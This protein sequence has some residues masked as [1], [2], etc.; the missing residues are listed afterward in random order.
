MR[1]WKLAALAVVAA[2]V[3]SSCGI[4]GG[5]GGSGKS[6]SAVFQRAIQVFPGVGVRVLGVNVGTVDSIKPVDNGVQVN[7]T[8]SDSDTK[9]PEDVQAVIAPQSLL[10][11]RFVQLFPAYTGGPELA[12]GSTIP[13]SRTGVPAEPDELLASLNNYLGA[14][15][16]STVNEFVTNAAKILKGN[17]ADLNA[18]IHHGAN[19]LQTLADKRDDLAQI[20]V[21]FD[22]LSRALATRQSAVANLIHTYNS[23]AGTLVSNRSALEGTID[24]LNDASLQL[25]SLLIAHRQPLHTD[26]ENLTSTAQTLSR[27]IGH[28]ART[29]HWASLLF[30]AAERA[31]DYN[32][33]WLRLNNQGQELAA[34][35]LIRLEQR[36]MGLC[37]DLGIPTCSLPSYWAQNVP[38]LF[39]FKDKCTPPKT[40][41]GGPI[42]LPTN[43]SEQLSQAINQIHTLADFLLSQADK[44]LCS[45][46]PNPYRCAEQKKILLECANSS[47]PRGCLEKH[48]VLLQCLKNAADVQACLQKHKDDDVKQVVDQLL[49]NELGNQAVGLVGGLTGG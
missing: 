48:V 38:G 21:E 1:T 41:N 16:S 25:A 47:D 17:G 18:L 32:H 9:I 43:P 8:I 23:V 44:L 7:F 42:Q 26:V 45:N 6:Y 36:L 22:K 12:P 15:K 34:M 4:I 5:G 46:E 49:Q 2:A 11:E 40:K 13:L 24:G 20:I 33:D 28:L 31:V 19:V 37:K 30:H 39:C 3:T 27:D 35:I 29:G 10:G 14:I